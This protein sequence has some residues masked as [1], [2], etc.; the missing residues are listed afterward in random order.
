MYALDRC[1]FCHSRAELLSSASSVVSAQPWSLPWQQVEYADPCGQG[2]AD[3][4]LPAETSAL[5]FTSAWSSHHS[6]H[7]GS[8]CAD[9]TELQQCSAYWSAVLDHITTSVHHQCCYQAGVWSSAKGPHHRCHYQATNPC[10]DTFQ[11]M[12]ARLTGTDRPVTK[13]CRSLW[14]ADNNALLVPRQAGVQCYWS[15]IFKQPSN[16]HLDNQ[17][18]SSFQ[19]ETEKFCSPNFMTLQDTRLLNFVC[20]TI[21]LDPNQQEGNAPFI[22][23]LP[24]SVPNRITNSEI[25]QM[26]LPKY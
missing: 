24:I 2:D 1:I 7:R 11:T 20:L 12:Y 23:D 19:E 26:D 15:C 3:M 10:L 16:R 8:A 6:R 22:L 13:L 4:F 5:D 9:T 18:H 14:S 17:Q 25:L 21:L